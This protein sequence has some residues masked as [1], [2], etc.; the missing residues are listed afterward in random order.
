MGE[1]VVTLR[2][3]AVVVTHEGSGVRLDACIRSLRAGGGVGP[4]VVVDNSG[5][6]SPDEPA[7]VDAEIAVEPRS[8][9]GGEATGPDRHLCVPNRGYGAAV[10]VGVA[11]PSLAAV[12]VIAV[13]NDDVVVESDWL[14]AILPEFAH[15]VRIGAVQPQLVLAD[16]DPPLVNSLGVSIGPDGAGTDIGHGASSAGVDPAPHD[17]DVFT[18]GAVVFRRRFL[19]DV[20]GFD[21]RYFLYYEDVD[22]ARRG[23]AR[24]WRYRCAP[25]SVVAHA[26]GATTAGL[27]DERIRLQERNRLITAV[28]FAPPTTIARALWLSARRLRHP[29]RRAHACAAAGAMARMP[30]A[31]F[32][33]VRQR[34]SR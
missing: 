26:M 28:R 24:G 11:D 4:I 30:G 15:D 17:I 5:R 25:V 16:T 34:R 3:G 2:V 6:G 7:S 12:D 18:A 23:T 1:R 14:E 31:V 10:N 33:R 19:D 20:G 13:L 8:A 29:P 27:G 9:S 22:L 32:E 21:E